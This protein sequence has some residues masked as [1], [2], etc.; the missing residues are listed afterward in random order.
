M[1][2][3]R[4]KPIL[5][6][7]PM[8]RAILA[9]QK[10]QTRRVVKPQPEKW[11]DEYV[12]SA[13]PATWLP[14]GAF[15]KDP[16][17]FLTQGKPFEARMSASPVRCPYGEVGALLWVRETWARHYTGH[18]TFGSV[19]YRADLP[20]D[21][22]AA[23]TANHAFGL[24]RW[25][26]SI[27][28]PRAACRLELIVS[29]IRVERLQSITPDDARAEGRSLVKGEPVGYFPDTWDAINGNGAWKSNPWVWAI[30]FAPLKCFLCDK[31]ITL[32]RSLPIVGQ[33]PQRRVCNE[34]ECL[35]K[36]NSGR[37][38]GDALAKYS[39]SFDEPQQPEMAAPQTE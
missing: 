30:T 2:E 18:P 8:V 20:D 1:S 23:M 26:P 10:V 13:A 33:P 9:G 22:D 34:C 5:F 14:R 29:E 39:K 7:S 12:P 16:T 21:P 19:H 6:S 11:I 38:I 36:R 25:K 35:T 28:M 15:I 37:K 27:H 4:Q 24:M 3:L 32:A 31:L 17:G